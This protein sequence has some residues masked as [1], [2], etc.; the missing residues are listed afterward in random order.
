MTAM[1]VI[2]DIDEMAV[3]LRVDVNELAMRW[4]FCCSSAKSTR[5]LYCC[6]P[7]RLT[8]WRSRRDGHAI[9]LFVRDVD[10]LA[11]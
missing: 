5:W 7:A 8:R 2:T 10:K 9:L 4:A 3:M 6:L 11:K 1:L